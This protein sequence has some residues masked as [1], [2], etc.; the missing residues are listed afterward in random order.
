M[1]SCRNDRIRLDVVARQDRPQGRDE[2]L[3]HL[4][5]PQRQQDRRQHV[6]DSLDGDFAQWADHR[7]RIDRD[8]DR[9]GEQLRLGAEIVV[10]QRGVDACIGGDRADRC[11]VDPVA[12]EQL[13][14]AGE[15]ALAGVRRPG[16]PPGTFALGVGRH[17]FTVSFVVASQRPGPWRRPRSRST[18]TMSR[19]AIAVRSGY[20]PTCCSASRA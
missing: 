15:N 8:V 9:R 18:T 14:S 17:S 11:L 5:I 12:G 1:I 3:A 20:A 2:P 19:N 10:H 7:H 13:P 16:W 4:G 6:A